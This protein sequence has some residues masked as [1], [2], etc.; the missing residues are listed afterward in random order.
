MKEILKANRQELEDNLLHKRVVLGNFPE[1]DCTID[2]V[3]IP[4]RMKAYAGNIV[5]IDRTFPNGE[6]WVFKTPED[7]YNYSYSFT[8]IV[9]I[10]E[11]ET[12]TSECSFKKG[13]LVRV[14][15]NSKTMKATGR[16]FYGVPI[17]EGNIMPKEIENRKIVIMGIIDNIILPYYVDGDYE[18]EIITT[19]M[20]ELIEEGYIDNIKEQKEKTRI[21]AIKQKILQDYEIIEEMKSKVDMKQLKKA[22]AGALKLIPNELVGIDLT[23]NEWAFNKRHIYK[24]LGNQLSI[25]QNIEYE[26]DEISV[27]QDRERIYREFPGTY[28]VIEKLENREILENKLHHTISSGFTVY[29]RPY[30]AGEKVSKMLDEAFKSEKLNIFYSNII[31]QNRIKGI[32]E[33]SINPIEYLL[34]SCNISGW[35]SCHA[36]YRMGNGLSF[37]SY[38]AG[39]FSYMCDNVSMIAF[40]HD[41]KLYD[42]QMNKQKIQAH[43]KNWRQMIWISKDLQTFVASRQYPNYVPE[44][45][46]SVRELLE[47][48]ITGKTE[49]L[50]VHSTNKD[51]MKEIVENKPYKEGIGNLHYNDIIHGYDG[52]L[53]YRKGIE[54]T[55]TKIIVGTH[56]ACPKCGKEILDSAGRPM[57]ERCYRGL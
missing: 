19:D 55:D 43:S 51:K 31:A 36:I 20:L 26:K 49:E 37:G 27:S 57:C 48:Q 7:R 8:N 9:K 33:I 10:I 42:F 3:Y 11:G 40:R 50:W 22:Y 44:V 12:Q 18:Q 17:V 21:G 41:G 15:S 6:Y 56:P 28:Y 1:G 47:K 24:M 13:D 30:K 34:M 46:K 52:D 5:T 54:L 53:C 45:A 35:T 32:I 23:L 4:D 39:I 2:G 29:S 38:S 16:E 14:K 25:S